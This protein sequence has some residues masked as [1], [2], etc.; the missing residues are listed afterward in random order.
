MKPCFLPEVKAEKALKAAGTDYKMYIYDGAKHA[1][2]N[3]T[4]ADRYHKEAA[5]LAW[6]R[7][8]TFFKEKL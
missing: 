7:T 1:F 4:R 8:I 5:E 3:D 6:K 2:F